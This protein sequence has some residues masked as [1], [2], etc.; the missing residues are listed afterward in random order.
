VSIS[1][2]VILIL[3]HAYVIKNLKQATLRE[4]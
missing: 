2:G 4:T 1:L 3:I